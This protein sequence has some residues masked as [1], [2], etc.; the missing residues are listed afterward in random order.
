M[1]H[2]EASLHEKYGPSLPVAMVTEMVM[3][4]V[5]VKGGKI[6]VQIVES[7]EEKHGSNSSKRIRGL[8]GHICSGDGGRM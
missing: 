3:V 6:P 5:M 8:K 4:M 1:T 2:F 7:R